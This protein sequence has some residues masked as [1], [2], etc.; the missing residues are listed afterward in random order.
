MTFIT[1]TCTE[2]DSTNAE[3]FRRDVLPAV[4]LWLIAERQT[5][6]RGQRGRGWLSRPGASMTASLALERKQPQGLG[7]LA[8]VAG[9]A[10]AEALA[11]FGVDVGLKWPNDIYARTADGGWAKAGGILCE[12][13]ARGAATRVVVGVGLNL[14]APA[15]EAIDQAVTG[16]FVDPPPV[17]TVADAV[18]QALVVAIDEQFTHGFAIVRRR[19]SAL[20]LLADQAVT[21]LPAGDGSAWTGTARG[22]DAQGGLRVARDGSEVIETLLS[23]QVSI[24]L[25]TV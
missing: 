23:G 14:A 13:R 17:A 16:L 20:D 4:P 1:E 19:W 18:G 2:I 8:L 6:G 21:I 3:L 7:S 5:A 10:V 11:G 15:G 22:I 24:R 12:A 9:V 25:K